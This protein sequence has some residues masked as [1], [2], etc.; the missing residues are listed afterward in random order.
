ML[1]TDGGH[2]KPSR[3]VSGIFLGVIVQVL[4]V[5]LV[6]A[7]FDPPIE[8]F[9]FLASERHR[10]GRAVG[11]LGRGRGLADEGLV[12]QGFL[13]G[14]IFQATLGSIANLTVTPVQYV[15]YRE[16]LRKHGA[17]KAETLSLSVSV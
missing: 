7:E 6:L 2:R 13:V 1:V 14:G 17:P 10:E 3:L 15:L 5:Q 12:L 16:A 8:V 9:L 4:V 11:G